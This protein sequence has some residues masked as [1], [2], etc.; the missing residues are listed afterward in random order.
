VLV[1]WIIGDGVV[2]R[3]PLSVMK[4]SNKNVDIALEN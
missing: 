2:R 1:F 3:A 4:A